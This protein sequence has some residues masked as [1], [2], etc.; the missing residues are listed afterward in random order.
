MKKVLTVLSVIAMVF[1]F[2]IPT[3]FAETFTMTV[4][5]STPASGVSVTVSP[6]DTTG[7][8][9]GTTQF[10]RTYNSGTAV[11]LTA[12]ATAGGN[13]FKEWQKNG[14][15]AGTSRTI[16]VTVSANTTMTAVYVTPKLT[17]ASFNPGPRSAA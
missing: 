7:K 4:A 5:S 13:I 9:S 12:A 1:A 14:E 6:N 3:A 17:V 8:G 10:T 11:T 15:K 16:S 2:A